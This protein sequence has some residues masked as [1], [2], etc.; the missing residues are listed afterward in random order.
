MAGLY[1]GKHMELRKLQKNSKKYR[2]YFGLLLDTNNSNVGLLNDKKYSKLKD[3]LIENAQKYNDI[4]D[5]IKYIKETNPKMNAGNIYKEFNAYIEQQLTLCK[6]IYNDL[7]KGELK[8][9]KQTEYFNKFE[10][11]KNGSC[12]ILSDR[13]TKY[14]ELEDCIKKTHQ[15]KNQSL[16]L[17]HENNKGKENECEK[18]IEKYLKSCEKLK[19]KII[20]TS[21]YKLC[22]EKANNILDYK[23]TEIEKAIDFFKENMKEKI[24]TQK[25]NILKLK[26]EINKE[27]IKEQQDCSFI[28]DLYE[29]R[30]EAYYGFTG[31]LEFKYREL[32]EIDSKFKNNELIDMKK[33]VSII[34]NYEKVNSD[35]ESQKNKNNNANIYGHLNIVDNNLGDHPNNKQLKKVV[36]NNNNVISNK[37]EKNYSNSPYNIRSNMNITPSMEAYYLKKATN[38]VNT[39]PKTSHING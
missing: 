26:K 1:F 17:L 21:N 14:K 39:L 10:K 35:F 9:E 19:N 7:N 34:D 37:R 6:I 24:K 23:S 36:L 16:Y 11:I 4:L 22:E 5:F 8:E 13:I 18:N 38:K 25:K 2:E 29:S 33:F 28:E 27:I 32:D 3:A 30:C 15:Y 31:E 20:K 12:G